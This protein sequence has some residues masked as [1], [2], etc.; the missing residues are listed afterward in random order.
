MVLIV[1]FA[2]ERGRLRAY[3]RGLFEVVSCY[4]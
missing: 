1:C 2:L 3:T 4:T